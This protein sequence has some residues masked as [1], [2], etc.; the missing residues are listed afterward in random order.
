LKRHREIAELLLQLKQLK[1]EPMSH[2]E[3]PLT[4]RDINVVQHAG[5]K[6]EESPLSKKER[7]AVKKAKKIAD[8]AKAV[9]SA[10]IEF[11]SK[12]LH[13]KDN[14]TEPSGIKEYL[15]QDEDV[16]R[17]ASFHK[18]TSNMRQIRSEL[19]KRDR[20][21]TG[22]QG[23]Q[24]STEEMDGLLQLLN[25]SPIYNSSSTEERSL[26]ATLRKKIGADLVQMHNEHEQLLMRKAGFWRWASKKK[27]YKRL[28]ANGTFWSQKGQDILKDLKEDDASTESVT[29]LDTELDSTEPETDVTTPDDESEDAVAKERLLSSA[30]KI[31]VT[32]AKVNTEKRSPK[33]D[34][35]TTVVTSGRSKSNTKT[36]PADLKLTLVA[37]GGLSKMAQSPTPKTA[38]YSPTMYALYDDDE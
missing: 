16:N 31:L 9:T 29:M 23:F 1:P 20:H 25:V 4:P 33:D 27:A 14:V 19:V 7:K 6:G 26:V 17:N 3:S 21:S 10:D 38:K 36:P 8:M 11:V 18:G 13:P 12:V 32:P 24:V 15:Q 5:G 35:W 34:G 28:V 30:K 22:T 2:Q 37:N